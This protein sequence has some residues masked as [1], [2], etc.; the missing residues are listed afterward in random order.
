MAVQDGRIL[1]L[2]SQAELR[3]LPGERVRHPGAA[4]IPGFVNAHTHLE[5]TV[6]RGFLENRSFPEWIRHLV[7]AKYD[8][9][10]RD[11]LAVSAEL[12]AIESLRAGVTAVGDA[13]DTGTAWDAML[14]YGLQGVAYQEVFGPAESS[15]NAAMTALRSKVSLH[16]ARETETQRV[17]VSPHA[18]YTVSEA[19]YRASHEYARA[20]NLRVAVHIA[21][22]RDEVAFV[23][24]GAGPFADALRARNIPVTARRQSPLAWLDQ[25][26]LIRPETLLIHAVEADAPDLDRIEAGGATVVHCPKSNAKLGH[27]VARVSEMIRRGIPVGIGSDSVASNNVI[28]MFE[29]MRTAIFCQRSAQERVDALSAHEAFR[30]ATIGGAKCLGLENHIG[31]LE[32][33]KRADFVVVDLSGVPL[34]PVYDPIETMVFSACRADVRATYVG[35]KEFSANPSALIARA[36]EIARSL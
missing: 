1:K 23:H 3:D 19:L 27:R 13:M 31:S 30:M 29:E 35:G 20:E 12:G 14:Q 11:A 28:D 10:D 8:V 26:G 15:L 18:P 16:R 2:G 9:L 36:E 33:G 17:G 24:D 22:S 32:A 25:L 7:H 4:I 21:E 5:L 34:Q 6:F